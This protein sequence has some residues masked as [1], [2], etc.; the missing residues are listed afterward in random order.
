MKKKSISSS[1]VALAF[2]LGMA[3]SFSSGVIPACASDG[4]DPADPMVRIT[5]PPTDIN[6]DAVLAAVA[7]DV[8]KATGIRESMITYYWQTFDT[9]VYEG[10]RTDKPL[11]VDLYVPPFFSDSDVQGVL[12]ALADAL[13]DHAGADRKWLFIHTHFPFPE[14]VYIAGGIAKWD[15]YRGLPNND[16][17]DISERALNKFLFND[18]SFV[19]QCLWRFGIAASGGSDLGELL[20]VTSRV[21]DFDRES[22]YNAWSD[23]ARRVR[24]T[25]DEFAAASHGQSAKEAYFRAATYF[26]ASSIYLSEDDPRRFVAWQDGRAAFLKAAALSD[27]SITHV[28]IPY[29]KTTLPGY[30]VTV[31]NSGR[32][33]PLLLIQTGLDGTAEDLYFIMAAQAVKRGYNCLI[34]EGPG[35]GEMITLQNIPFRYDWEKA[36]T[37]VV[38]FALSR[39]EVDADRIALIGYSMGGYLA[40]RALAFEKRIRWGIVDGGVYS[41]FEGTMTKFPDEVKK[42]VGNKKRRNAVNELVYKE[43]EKHPDVNQFINQM[44]WTFHA[45]TPFDLFT[46]L[47]KF[48]VADSI[49]KITAEMLVVNSCKDPIAGSYAQAKKFYNALKTTKSYIEFTE[50]QGAQFHCQSGAPLVSSERILNWLDERAK[51]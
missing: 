27:G 38:D 23:M 51:P 42:D 39:P 14:Q 28:R 10:K 12:N 15:T 26:N 34:Y 32:K 3:L 43:M 11:F 17:R 35:Q 25:A 44:L 46:K 21:E 19:F 48:T 50:D 18:A 40:P 9:I 13:V 20:T 1:F 49:D 33:R 30:L 8:S 37:S 41:A 16:P 45:D 7:K 4:I 24:S 36:V 5:S 2:V 6:V 22:W 29:E 31:D 47:Q